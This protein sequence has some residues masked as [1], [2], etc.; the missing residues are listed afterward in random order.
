MKSWGPSGESDVEGFD[1][2][3]II[4]GWVKEVGQEDVGGRAA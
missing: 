2:M 1:G 4:R 3:V